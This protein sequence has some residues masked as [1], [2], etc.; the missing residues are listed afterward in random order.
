MSKQRFLWILMCIVLFGMCTGC[1]KEEEA[2]LLHDTLTGVFRTT[3]I[4]LPAHYGIVDAPVYRDGQ[5]LADILYTDNAQPGLS[6]SYYTDLNRKRISFDEDNV[7]ITA[8]DDAASALR[9]WKL[10]SVVCTIDD[11]YRL[12]CTVDGAVVGVIDLPDTFH[13]TLRIDKTGSAPVD[14]EFSVLQIVCD[15]AKNL[16]VLTNK[17]VCAIDKSGT[18]LWV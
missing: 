2:S 9:E 1:G 3:F 7:T 18:L 17:G 6:T 11:M 8:V 5:F 13:H 10:D 4:E 12:T 15:T 16:Y 14:S